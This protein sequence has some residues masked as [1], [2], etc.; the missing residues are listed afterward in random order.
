VKEAVAVAA[1]VLVGDG[2]FEGVGEGVDEGWSVG[3]LDWMGGGGIAIGGEVGCAFVA[4]GIGVGGGE[5]GICGGMGVGVAVGGAFSMPRAEKGSVTSPTLNDFIFFRIAAGVLPN[6]V[7]VVPVSAYTS[8]W[9][10][11]ISRGDGQGPE[12]PPTPK[13]LTFCRTDCAVVIPAPS[14]LQAGLFLLV[15]T[16]YQRRALG[17]FLSVRR[18]R[19]WV[20]LLGT[21]ENR[22]SGDAPRPGKRSPAEE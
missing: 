14:L 8:N 12:Y 3:V 15:T 4:T 19:S 2:V 16:R 11:P 21:L 10:E 6:W 17:S 22:S 5:V 9:N 18:T 7:A 20:A 1:A 13:L